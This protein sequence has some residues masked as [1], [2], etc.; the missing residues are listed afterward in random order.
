MKLY[1]NEDIKSLNLIF[2][3]KMRLFVYELI[4]EFEL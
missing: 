3:I 2:R 1:P 4:R